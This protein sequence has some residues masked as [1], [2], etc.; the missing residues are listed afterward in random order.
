[1][2]R[3]LLVVFG[4]TGDLAHKKIYPAV[5]NLYV[6]GQLPENFALVSI[7]R[8]DKTEDSFRREAAESIGRYTRE[9]SGTRQ[10]IDRIVSRFYYRRADFTAY[11]GYQEIK[12][13][14]DTLDG[15]YRTV[16]NRV[17][18]PGCRPGAFRHHCKKYFPERYVRSGG[19]IQKGCH[20][21][22]V[23]T[24]PS[25]RFRIEPDPHRCLS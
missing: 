18:L 6:S 19:G 2:I 10:D 5:Y 16:G 9:N 12:D 22:A 24:G 17:F 11:D 15:R 7:G 23:W 21:K 25:F 20:R 8:R 1:M 4:G 14:L 3:C 13:Y